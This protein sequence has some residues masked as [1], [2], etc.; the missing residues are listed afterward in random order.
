M[1]PA[2]RTLLA[3]LLLAPTLAPAAAPT[4]SPMSLSYDVAWGSVP[5]GEGSL[6]LSAEGGEGCFRYELRTDP[7]GIIAWTYG[8]PRETSQFCVADGRVVPSRMQFQNPKRGKDSFVLD[9]DWQQGRVLGGRNGPLVIEPG[10]VD[11]LSV[12]QAGRLWVK[13]HVGERDPG[14][15]VLAVADHKRVKAYTFTI[16]G[17]GTVKTEAGS[18]EAVRFERIDDPKT[19]LRFWLAPELDY[20]PVKVEH[21]EDGEAKLNLS[22]RRRP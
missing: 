11:R 6:T 17:R 22:L 13:A 7:I 20:M 1:N 3:L 8:A 5:L 12:Q 19:T 9:Y 15:L 21:I 10:T 18:F 16:A 2:L 14:R 4:L